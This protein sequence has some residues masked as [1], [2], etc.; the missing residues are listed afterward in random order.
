MR[1]SRANVA[2]PTQRGTCEAS[3]G[4][5]IPPADMTRGRDERAVTSDSLGRGESPLIVKSVMRECPQLAIAGLDG[6]L[7]GRPVERAGQHPVDEAGHNQ[8][9]YPRV[10]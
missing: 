5:T 3:T 4:P 9:H 6:R 2:S 1:G 10:V 7:L 8:A